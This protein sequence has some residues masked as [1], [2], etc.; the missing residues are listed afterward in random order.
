MAG[1]FL[2]PQVLIKGTIRYAIAGSIAFAVMTNP[3][4]AGDPFRPTQVRNIGS[5]TEAAFNQVFR[6]GDYQ[7]AATMLQTAMTAEPDEPLVYAMQASFAYTNG[8]TAGLASYGKKT[9]EVAQRLVAL[10]G[11]RGNLYIAVGHFLEGA[12]TL[13][14]E[15][16]VSGAPKALSRLRQVYEYLDKAEA[17]ASKDPELNLIKGYMDLMVAVNLPF[18]NP[19]QAISRLEQN[20]APR[21]LVDRGI[22]I[23]YRDLK[24]Y[25][26]A[27]THVDQ[28]LK[29]TNE[30]PELHYLK[31]QILRGKAQGDKNKPMMQNAIALFDQ[32]LTKRN[33]LP[34]TTVR[35]IERER[36][37]SAA[38]LNSW[39]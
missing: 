20:A 10:D 31:A 6:Y 19:E 35:Q 12:A 15:G 3:S 37:R 38:S 21:Y 8:D 13:S 34:P 36:R 7:G 24:N 27:L 18:A 26:K 2:F 1:W 32:A 22:A 23:A 30:N 39:K 25:D 5:K 9:L 11:L 29:A 17:I 33:Q 28:A 14:Q 4:M 16:T